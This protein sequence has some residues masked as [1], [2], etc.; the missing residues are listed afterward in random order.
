MYEMYFLIG[1]FAFQAKNSVLITFN[2]F[3]GIFHTYCNQSNFI[4][5]SKCKY[6]S[7]ALCFKILYLNTMKK[8]IFIIIPVI[9]LWSCIS[10]PPVSAIKNQEKKESITGKRN[11]YRAAYTRSFSLQH[12]KLNVAFNWKKKE[13]LGEAEIKLRPYFYFT[14]SVFL[15]ARGM[16]LKEVS[17]LSGKDK[18]IPLKFDYDSSL[19]KIKLDRTYSK[20]ESLTLYINYISRPEN[21]PKGG[22]RAIQK[23]KGLYFI[24]ADSLDT[25]TPTQLWTQGE[26]ESNSAWF[27]T[28][29]DP[30]QKMTQEIYMTVDTAMTTLS[31][32]LLL[33]SVNN[34]NGTK[35]DYWKQSLPT[36]P[37]L[38][39]VAAGKFA[40]VKDKWKN[41]EVN[42][43]V[44]PPYEK[45]AKM[46]FGLTPEMLTFFSD[47]LGV[48]YPWEK[49]SQVVVHDYV[50][51]AM[52]NTTAVVHGTNMQQDIRSFMDGNYEDYISHELFHHWF[53]DLVTCESWSNI[54]LN[55]GFANYSEYL[56][57][58]HKYGREDAD[59]LNQNDQAGYLY[60]SAQ[61]DP[62]LFR[63]EYEDREDV[64]DGISYNKGGRVLHMLRKYVGDTAFFAALQHYLISHSYSSVEVSDLRL[65]FEKTTGEDLNWYFDQWFMHGGH[66][67]IGIEYEWNDSLHRETIT[68]K[69]KQDLS[70]NPLYKLPIDVDIYYNGKKER[71]RIVIEEYDQQF[72]FNLPVKPDLVNVD[73]E[74]MLLCN[75]SDSKTNA[76][77][78]F[79]YYHAPLYLDKYEAITKIGSSY[80]INSPEAKLIKE[81]L[82]DKYYNL[83]LTALNNVGELAL[84]QPDSIKQKL[85]SMAATD[86][87]SDVREKALSI[88][89]KN[90]SYS[91]LSKFYENALTD[92]SY[93]VVARAFKII[94]EKDS[95]KAKEIALTLEK[96]SGQVILLRLAEFYNN[97]SEDKI[98]FYKRALRF[99]SSYRRYAILKEFEKYLKASID[100]NIIKKGAEVLY[101]RAINKGSRIYSSY[102]STLKEI[103]TV[104]EKK[105]K[106]LEDSGNKAKSANEKNP[107]SLLQDWKTFQNELKEKISA[108]GK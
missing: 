88:L 77:F 106:T 69:Q 49:Y 53:G 16:E 67:T 62:P 61:S 3:S 41:I 19:I 9:F 85:M 17:L 29:E 47:K 87:S 89:G 96:D 82:N 79:Q 103:K 105:I 52:E 11:N 18:H 93:Q 56:W 44:D 108:L 5:Y 14:D 104:A 74:K 83:R 99:S 60:V 22:S 65:A 24:D 12:T 51:G 50:S 73:A 36:A 35:T 84:N 70:K 86:S 75:K 90:F 10:K 27:P 4:L 57:R 23:D 34:N 43:Y 72:S 58:E 92:S 40:V 98:D 38:A 101:S 31:N 15:N 46:I 76:E 1:D 8:S 33:S 32:G 64:Y 45:Y 68:I 13:L 80:T 48:Q 39:M 107:A 95:V 26:T 63:S 94:S 100:L 97:S 30:Q 25:D 42:Y 59:W 55:E 81:A 66:P 2:T 54:T 20:N 71:K 91:E 21:L 102:L 28:I 37:Y 78:I 7:S 6:L